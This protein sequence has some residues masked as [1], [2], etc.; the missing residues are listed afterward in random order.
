[1]KLL[2]ILL[3]L[4]SLTSC[5]KDPPPAIPI[6]IGD[7]MG[8]ALMDIPGQ[9]EKEYW[10]PSKLENSWITTQDGAA[11]LIA[12]CYDTDLVTA[13]KAIAAKK[14]EISKKTELGETPLGGSDSVDLR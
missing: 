1:M 5:R 3:C 14:S 4:F 9:A 11:E 10:P 2:T 7:G 6:G 12:W 13:K 8:G